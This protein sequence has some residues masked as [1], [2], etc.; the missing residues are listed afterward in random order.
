MTLDVIACRDR[1]FACRMLREDAALQWQRPRPL[2]GSPCCWCASSR[3]ATPDFLSVKQIP[4]GN[5]GSMERL[6]VIFVV[7]A[8]IGAFSNPGVGRA[9]RC[10]GPGGL[11]SLDSG[12]VYDRRDEGQGTVAH[13]RF[14][15]KAIAPIVPREPIVSAD[16]ARGAFADSRQHGDGERIGGKGPAVRVTDDLER[17]VVQRKPA[18][19]LRAR[20]RLEPM[21]RR[22]S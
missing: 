13:A 6:T 7:G 14:S 9:G 4:I 18:C 21:R 20:P 19:L 16:L 1:S 5:S 11:P 17:V 22:P 8:V 3:P 10:V 12:A 15:L 2:C